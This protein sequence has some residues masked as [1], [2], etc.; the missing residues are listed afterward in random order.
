MPDE[1]TLKAKQAE[2]QRKYDQK[3]LMKTVSF[4]LEREKEL[5]DFMQKEIPDFSNWVKDQIR[6]EFKNQPK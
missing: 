1:K 2:Y 5:V 3:R 6:K 4:H